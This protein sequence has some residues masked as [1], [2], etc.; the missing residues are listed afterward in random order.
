MKPIETYEG[1]NGKLHRCQWAAAADIIKSATEME[2]KCVTDDPPRNRAVRDTILWMADAIRK[3]DEKLKKERG[4]KRP[5]K[6]A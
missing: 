1:A 3:N 6:A 4:K 5:A 2:I